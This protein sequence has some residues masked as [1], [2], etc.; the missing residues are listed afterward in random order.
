MHQLLPNPMRRARAGALA[1]IAAAAAAAALVAATSSAAIAAGSPS[2]QTR[3]LVVW[4][5]TNG[6]GTAGSVFYTLNYTN[7]SGH[8]CTLRGY[9][10]VS[11]I[12]LRGR[13]IG[14]PASRDSTTRVRTIPLPNN[15][16]ATSVLRIVD[17][18]VIANCGRANAAGLRIFPPNQGASKTVPFPFGACSRTSVLTVRAVR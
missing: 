5:N 11:A 14:K 9:P 15:A 4:L 1:L 8:R 18:G 17:N 13:R 10:G 3:G 16:T 12:N 7:Q 6:N 2:C